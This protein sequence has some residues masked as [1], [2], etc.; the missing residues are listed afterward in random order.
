MPTTLGTA[1]SSA[2]GSG[3][4][5]ARRNTR[6]TSRARRV[7][8]PNAVRMNGIWEGLRSGRVGIV[9]V[10]GDG[11][12]GW[13]ITRVVAAASMAPVGRGAGTAAVGTFGA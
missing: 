11:D 1:I 4:F 13:A 12:V 3:S 10:L 9:W 8:S 7:R 5:E 2:I 6:N